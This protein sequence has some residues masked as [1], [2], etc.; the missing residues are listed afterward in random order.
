MSE[1]AITVRTATAADAERLSHLASAT[2]ALGC[3]VGTDPKHLNE[4][5]STELT[6]ARFR[7]FLSDGAVTILLAEEAHQLAGFTMLV[8]DCR[9]PQIAAERPI[10]LRKFYV[11]PAHHGSGVAQAL[12]RAAEPLLDDH[13]VGWLSVYSGNARAIAFY[14]KWGFEVV[15]THYF[16]VGGDPQK[17]FVMRREGRKA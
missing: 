17:D 12:M 14:K 7:E 6:P 15:G 8:R 9:H 16:N 1:S 11:D 4:F 2:F 13:D 10:E 5:I 3:P